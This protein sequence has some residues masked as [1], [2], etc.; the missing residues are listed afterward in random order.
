M[1]LRH[2]PRPAMLSGLGEATGPIA[3]NERQM[4]HCAKLRSPI[5]LGQVSWIWTSYF[6]GW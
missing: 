5:G 4:E 6:A 2:H 1:E 3:T